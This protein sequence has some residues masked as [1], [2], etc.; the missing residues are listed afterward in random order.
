MLVC[1]HEAQNRAI[2]LYFRQLTNER[3]DVFVQR[4]PRLKRAGAQQGS[5]GQD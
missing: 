4:V 2:N 1:H 5:D 3:F